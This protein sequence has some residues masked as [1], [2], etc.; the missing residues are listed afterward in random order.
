M[1]T[2]KPKSKA[3]A[4]IDY[5]RMMLDSSPFCSQIWDR[6]L[7][8]IDC[9]VA[10]YELYGFKDKQEYTERFIRDCSPE[11]QPDGRRSDEKAV[12]LVNFAFNEGECTFEWMHKMPDSDEL[13][14]AEVTL[15]RVEYHDD[16]LV[17]GYTRDLREY[18]KM[19]DEIEHRDRMLKAANMASSLLLNS[20]IETFADNLVESMRLL[21]KAIDVHC[22]YLWKNTD[23]D[24][25]LNCFQLFEWSPDKTMFYDSTPYE[26]DSV[27]PGWEEVLS[28]GGSI[29]GIVSEMNEHVQDHLTPSGILSILVVPI[30][31]DNVFWG[32]VGFDDCKK[33]RI[34]TSE[35]E[36]VMRTASLQ[37]ANAFLHAEMMQ[38]IH[39]QSL[40]LEKAFNEA[41]KAN[42]A[43]SE[44]LSKMSHEMRTPL[45]TVINM[46]TIAERQDSIEKKD[47]CL[48]QIKDAS[49]YLLG[50]INDVLDISKIEAGKLRLEPIEFDFDNMIQKVM[51]VVGIHA[52]NKGQKLR[53]DLDPTIPN[54]LIGDDQ[55]FSQVITNIFFNAIKF[56]ADNG[57]ISLDAKVLNQDDNKC[58]I[59]ISIADNGIGIS[60]EA[61]KR[62]FDSFEQAES[63]T[64]RYY[65]GTG[66]G[67]TISKKII[68]AMNGKIW[69]ESVLGEG[70][71]F[72]ISIGFQKA[73]DQT[74]KINENEF[75]LEDYENLDFSGYN[76]MYVDDTESN[77]IIFRELLDPTNIK[78]NCVPSGE[79]AI[80]LFAKKHDYFDLIFMDLL[81]PGIDGYEATRR[82]R[83]LDLPN[84][85]TIPIIACSASVFSEVVQQC[86][87]S[88]MDGHVEKPINYEKLLEILIE[89][90]PEKEN[91]QKLVLKNK[92]I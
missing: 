72:H 36:E 89:A 44:F 22:V 50:V 81:M 4:K 37:L 8:T 20:N 40:S 52:K 24:G 17:I 82:I 21:A 77:R 15:R 49:A 60:D 12:E 92:N 90:L 63:G 59:Q 70:S 34:F 76:I 23:I 68:E 35:E 13:M 55:R 6:N 91:A 27:V 75:K 43:K 67:L 9:N 30:F 62:L 26:Y 71:T 38:N 73:L 65:G 3:Q 78:I 31:I 86:L 39:D 16:Y 83:E 58:N 2:N 33:E 48:V 61:Q 87:D 80:K 41:T 45:N 1:E 47:A 85:K 57:S 19:M 66:L 53:V 74:R 56:T 25:V 79:G 29:N 64:S 28:R 88:G 46:V 54:I 69:V 14:P 5:Y 51:N 11:F 32:F 7:N 42:Q 10:A 18:K 84:A